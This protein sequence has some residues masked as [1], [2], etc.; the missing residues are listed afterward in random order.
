ML[1]VFLCWPGSLPAAD[2]S[3][4]KGGSSTQKTRRCGAPPPAR[5]AEPTGVISFRNHCSPPSL[6]QVGAT[7]AFSLKVAPIFRAKALQP[8]CKQGFGAVEWARF[9]EPA[10]AE[11]AR[12]A[13]PKG[14]QAGEDGPLGWGWLLEEESQ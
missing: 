12:A 6:G 11:Q 3:G 2:N 14:Q 1:C 7:L 10:T 8:G 9:G 13:R 4:G 5:S